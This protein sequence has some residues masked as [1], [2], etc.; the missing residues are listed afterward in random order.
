MVRGG[1]HSAD[2]E[3]VERSRDEI[4]PVRKI[5]PCVGDQGL[6]F[7]R[8]SVEVHFMPKNMMDSNYQRTIEVGTQPVL[9]GRQR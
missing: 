3:I 6:K 1:L 7:V 2:V 4:L 8:T 5:V 9:G